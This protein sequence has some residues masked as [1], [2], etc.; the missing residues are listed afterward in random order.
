MNRNYKYSKSSLE[1]IKSLSIPL[2]NVCH[3]GL[4]IANTRMMPCPDICIVRGLTTADKQFKIFMKGRKVVGDGYI[5]IGETFT[6]ADGYDNISDHQKTDLNGRAL[7]FDFCAWVSGTNYDDGNVA[8]IATCF[9]AAASN[10]GLN[11]EYGGNYK[12]I[13]DGGHLSLVTDKK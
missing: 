5:K 9:Y 7:A 3:E 8:L 1:V 13:S 10:L 4:I 6:N 12:S 11:I 2:Q